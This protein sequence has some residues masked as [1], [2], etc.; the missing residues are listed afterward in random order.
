[1]LRLVLILNLNTVKIITCLCLGCA[2]DVRIVKTHLDL[3]HCHHSEG[4]NFMLDKPN[5]ENMIYNNF[6][7]IVLKK[8]YILREF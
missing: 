3:S 4:R 1:M 2:E 7:T 6:F 8:M 5:K